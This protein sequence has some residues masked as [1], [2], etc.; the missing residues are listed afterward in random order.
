MS[1]VLSIFTN[2]K[3]DELQKDVYTMSILRAL[4]TLLTILMNLP[5][6]GQGIIKDTI[7]RFRDTPA[8]EL[9]IIY[10]DNNKDSKAYDKICDFIFQDFDNE[11]YKY[12][13]DYFKENKLR[14]TK[15]KPVVPITKWVILKQ[16]KG[17]FY[18]YQPCDL[19]FH[20]RQSVND[21]SFI[22]WTG[23]GPV[24]NKIISQKK[25]DDNTFQLKLTGLYN[26]NRILIIH[27]IDTK[28][29][30]AVF[31]QI[32]NKTE[33]K[34]YLMIAADKI[35][36]VPIIVNDCMTQKQPELEFD[37]TDFKKLLTPKWKGK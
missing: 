6:T 1:S 17:Q 4:I 27:I 5:V 37:K 28:R 12:S 30:I 35:K 32:I 9:Q 13:I 11:S 20:Y 23:E 2:S 15:V 31:E 8:G 22:D 19:L 14:L 16:Y 21:T 3:P 7:F 34:Y 25:I 26:K 24:A 10:I 36:T 33:K 18:A 29:G